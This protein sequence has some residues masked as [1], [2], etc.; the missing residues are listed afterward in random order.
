MSH[1]RRPPK[2]RD[3]GW[4]LFFTLSA[5]GLICVICLFARIS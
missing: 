2:D 1:W 5:I 4:A 3:S